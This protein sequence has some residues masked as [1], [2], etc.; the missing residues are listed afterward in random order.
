MLGRSRLVS[1]LSALLFLAFSSGCDSH[2]E[3]GFAPEA[4][5]ST[6]DDCS[7]QII[8]DPSC[9]DEGSDVGPAYD[10]YHP[11]LTGEGL[12]Y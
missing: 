12:V 1:F 10:V 5:Y 2:D 9:N 6:T 4:V 8:P 11:E 7:T 3:I